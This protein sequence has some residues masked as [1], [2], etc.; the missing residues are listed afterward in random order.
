M[1]VN[2]ITS[3]A[4]LNKYAFFKII[5]LTSI[6]A[7]LA[8][9]EAIIFGNIKCTNLC[10]RILTAS[11]ILLLIS[12]VFYAF[13]TGFISFGLA[14]SGIQLLLYSA[15]IINLAAVVS[16]FI[17]VRSISALFALISATIVAAAIVIGLT[18][19]S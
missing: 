11:T 8:I 2:K 18:R 1:G 4:I 16:G 7:L 17:M 10:D 9:F 12:A 6:A 3:E 13:V 15:L 19:L 5:P 14:G